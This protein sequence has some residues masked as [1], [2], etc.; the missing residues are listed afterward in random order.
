MTMHKILL[1]CLGRTAGPSLAAFLGPL[2]HCGN[3]AS[4]SFFTG[5]S[6]VEVHLNWLNW[7]HFLIH[8]G[9]LLVI[10]IDCII[11]LSLFLDVTR[12]SVSTVS[13]FAQL[14]SGILCI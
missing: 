1:S 3:V 13:F 11:F 10:V 7:F 2:F 8:E 12:M 4:S 6:F 5:I 9:G 14:D